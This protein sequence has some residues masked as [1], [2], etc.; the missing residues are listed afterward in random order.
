MR[1]KAARPR[2][3]VKVRRVRQASKPAAPECCTTQQVSAPAP[4]VP[5][6]QKPWGAALVRLLLVF[7]VLTASGAGN[8]LAQYVPEVGGSGAGPDPST[9]TTTVAPPPQ[10]GF[11]KAI[12]GVFG[13][14]MEFLK[15]AVGNIFGALQGSFRP[16]ARTIVIIYVIIVGFNCFW[17]NFGPATKEL[18]LSCLLIVG[19]SGLVFET[20]AYQSWVM[21]P[22]I[23]TV[24]DLSNFF[25]SKGA[26]VPINSQGDIFIYM[27]STL[28]S[29]YKVS[30]Q[31]ERAYSSINPLNWLTSLQIWG[32]QIILGGSYVACIA[33]YLYLILQAWFAIFM[34]MIIGG[35]CLFF[36]AFKGTRFLA[37]AWFRSL[38]HEGLTIIFC[39][40]IMGISGNIIQELI[41]TLAGME[42]GLTGVFTPQFLAV[43]LASFMAC[44]MLLKAPQL[45]SSISG[46]SAGST[47]GIAAAV[48]TVA[49]MG[50][51]KMKG[52]GGGAAGF[53]MGVATGKGGGQGSLGRNIGAAIRSYTPYSD[54]KGTKPY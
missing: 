43:I 37:V 9:Y 19:L 3:R 10:G 18:G 26:G 7:M 50:Y 52:L 36:A 39:S 23:G 51:A 25:V 22:F 5:K 24:G 13:M 53:G 8:S 31:I 34:Y 4:E 54:S 16:F 32:A 49:G 28:E 30:G 40:L 1:T 14:Y 41:K 35:I 46:G 11:A 45:A 2:P 44:L 29:I 6:K 20:S 42:M 48:G 33:I 17:G 47:S 15:T 21:D 27:G 38:C 12:G